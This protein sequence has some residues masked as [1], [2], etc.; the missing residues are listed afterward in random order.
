MI[1]SRSFESL[2]LDTT[3]A[4]IVITSYSDTFPLGVCTT[5]CCQS[6]YAT[7]EAKVSCTHWRRTRLVYTG[8][9]LVVSS[10]WRFWKNKTVF[11]DTSDEEKFVIPFHAD[12]EKAWT[13]T[14]GFYLGPVPRVK[15]MCYLEDAL[16]CMCSTESR[17]LFM[18]FF[19][20]P[21][22]RSFEDPE[23]LQLH[24]LPTAK[25]F[26][27]TEIP[28][29]EVRRIN[30]FY[31]NM[32]TQLRQEDLEFPVY[33]NNVEKTEKERCEEQER[34]T[35]QRKTLIAHAENIQNSDSKLWVG[36]RRALQIVGVP[37]FIV[38]AILLGF[39]I[40]KRS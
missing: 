1:L 17:T 10:W 34:C 24:R 20:P 32:L 30:S 3:F 11:I 27:M 39:I 29:N 26:T 12:G 22:I 13:C 18:R 38:G 36:V 19:E 23:D 4:M 8:R 15:R 9:D 6:C 35:Y 2:E 31:D 33:V 40:A 21:V 14:C 25:R 37:A 28:W 5:W 7:K 16:T